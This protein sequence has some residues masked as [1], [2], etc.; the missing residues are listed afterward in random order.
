MK[1]SK[2]FAVTA[3]LFC[4]FLPSRAQVD[5]SMT[6]ADF[7]NDCRNFTRNP[8]ESVWV[9]SFWASYNSESLYLI[10]SLIETV[11]RY[12]NKPVRFVWISTDKRRG[13]WEG[14]LSRYNM[15]G[16]QLWLQNKEDYDFLRLAF[17]HKELPAIFVV[18]HTGQIRRVKMADLH[19][20]VDVL[21]KDLP[22]EPFYAENALVG[23]GRDEGNGEEVRPDDSG[24]WITHTVRR[25][26]TL[27]GIY[28]KYAVPVDKIKQLNNLTSSKIDIGQVLKIKQR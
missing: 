9:V 28:K 8:Q 14:A 19:A 22:Q 10:P 2:S 25:G 18:E 7:L 20:I 1:I 11:N 4:L 6:Y 24:S 12:K 16:E 27:Y 23:E 15:P 5:T 26:D 17:Q 3:L 13:N 21:C